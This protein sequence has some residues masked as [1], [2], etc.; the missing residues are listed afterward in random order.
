MLIDRSKMHLDVCIKRDSVIIVD[1]SSLSY[2]AHL[3]ISFLQRKPMN[4][5]NVILTLNIELVILFLLTHILCS[6]EIFSCVQFFLH[7]IVR[8]CALACKETGY[9]K[10][11]HFNVSNQINCNTVYLKFIFSEYIIFNGYFCFYVFI[12]VLLQTW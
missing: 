6:M 3:K 7:R 11:L 12:F 4:P 5:T 2:Q 8:S 9:I 1:Q 10:L